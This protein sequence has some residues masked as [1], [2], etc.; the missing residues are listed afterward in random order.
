CSVLLFLHDALPI[1]GVWFFNG[2][3]NPL[4]LPL[5]TRISCSSV[6]ILGTSSN[7]IFCKKGCAY[8]FSGG[9][10]NHTCSIRSFCSEVISSVWIMPFP[11]VISSKLPVFQSFSLPSKTKLKVSNPA[12]G[13]APP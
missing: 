13:C 9:S 7:S 11:A 6:L 8:R 1:Y 5:Y 12:C 3:I 10:T 4:L 2:E